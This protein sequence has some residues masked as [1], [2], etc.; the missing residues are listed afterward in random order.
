[1][2]T[3]K[4]QSIMAAL[5]DQLQTILTTGGYNSNLG[6]NVYEW[7]DTPLE[8][9]SLPALIYRDMQDSIAQTFGNQEHRLTVSLDIFDD[10]TASYMRG[11]IA[12][13]TKCLGA[14]LTL[15]GLCEDV[16]PISDEAIQAE[17][18]NRKIFGVSIKIIIAFVSLNWDPYN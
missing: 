13:V 2:P 12:D 3:P 6:S 15:G 14:N 18:D 5:E 8:S 4:R 7:R 16:L 9:G 1:M 17:H 11:L 10:C